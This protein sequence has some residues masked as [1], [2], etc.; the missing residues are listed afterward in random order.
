MSNL[1]ESIAVKVQKAFDF[2]V[3]KV[4]LSGGGVETPWF[5]LQRKDTQEWLGGG[6]VTTRYEPHQTDDVLAL[7]VIT[8]SGP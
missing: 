5:G 7:V 4:Q 2:D 8:N 1:I 3:E 6:S